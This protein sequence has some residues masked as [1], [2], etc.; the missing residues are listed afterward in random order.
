ML[1]D[2]AGGGR[3]IIVHMGTTLVHR[4]SIGEVG[5]TGTGG[6]G[7]NEK[8]RGL[9]APFCWQVRNVVLRAICL[10]PAPDVH[11]N[12]QF[13]MLRFLRKRKICRG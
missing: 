5:D 7:G 2:A 11:S 1:G 4:A 6:I 3:T 10:V 9:R 8:L 12:I 13:Y